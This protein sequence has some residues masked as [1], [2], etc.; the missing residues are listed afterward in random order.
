[1][2]EYSILAL[3]GGGTKGVLHV[4]ALKFLEEKFGILQTKFHNGFYGCSVGAIFAIGLAFGLNADSIIRMSRRFTS[5]DEILFKDVTLEKLNNS[6]VRKGLFSL[7]CLEDFFDKLFQSEGLYLRDKMIGDAPYPLYICATNIT[8]KCITTFKGRVPIFK[9]MGASAC[10]PFLFS[11]QILNN[12]AYVDGGY[13]TNIILSFVP[14]E[15]RKKLLTISIVYDDP[16]ITPI[17]LSKI[18]TLEYLYGLYKVSC[19]YERKVNMIP[20]NIQL[21]YNLASGISDVGEKERQEMIDKGYE[22][23]RSFFSC[24]S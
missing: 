14:S 9:A 15:D 16:K 8:K 19:I 11:P 5:F 2:E 17:R 23:T 24:S 13:L 7:E 22:L 18:S 6:V 1:M 20:N 4:G 3:G 12:S 21:N 10:I